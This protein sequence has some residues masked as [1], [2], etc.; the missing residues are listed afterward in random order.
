MLKAIETRPASAAAAAR[1]VLND[2]D[3]PEGF[4]ARR[5]GRLRATGRAQK[6][7]RFAFVVVAREKALL[8]GVIETNDV[9]LGEGRRK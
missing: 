8:F 6:D 7:D 9:T 5:V 4:A 1:I 2:F 3:F